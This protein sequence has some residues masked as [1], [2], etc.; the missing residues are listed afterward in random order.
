MKLETLA[1][2]QTL[3]IM[4]K[5]I[6]YYTNKLIKSILWIAKCS[7]FYHFIDGIYK[8]CKKVKIKHR[9]YYSVIH[10]NVFIMDNRFKTNIVYSSTY[11]TKNYKSQ[12]MSRIIIYAGNDF[13]IFSITEFARLYAQCNENVRK[14]LDFIFEKL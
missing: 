9:K 2:T 8:D 6:P 7:Y 1:H 10:E 4:N 5:I 13:G 12:T 14:R 3:N 11:N